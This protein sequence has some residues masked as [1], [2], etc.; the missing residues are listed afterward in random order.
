MELILALVVL[1]DENGVVHAQS[2]TGCIDAI[3]K[4]YAVGAMTAAL[5][6]A[7]QIYKGDM[8]DAIASAIVVEGMVADYLETRRVVIDDS[9][10]Q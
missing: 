7:V 8:P 2:Q 3:E 5:A 4:L 1:K 9:N 10:K 6:K